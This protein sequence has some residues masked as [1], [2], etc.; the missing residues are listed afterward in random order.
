MGVDT[1]E[2]LEVAPGDPHRVGVV[3]TFAQGQDFITDANVANPWVP[4]PVFC[5]GWTDH[6]DR[7][8]VGRFREAY[9]QERA[10]AAERLSGPD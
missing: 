4:D 9:D 10:R 8:P 5:T 2:D 3:L 1:W 7:D 6:P